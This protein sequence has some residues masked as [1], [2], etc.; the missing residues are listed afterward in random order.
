MHYSGREGCV[1]VC[2]NFI[3]E[4]INEFNLRFCLFSLFLLVNNSTDASEK[5]SPGCSML[6]VLIRYLKTKKMSLLLVEYGMQVKS[7]ACTF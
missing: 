4:N 7:G 3:D 6:P 2:M 5:I 1:L